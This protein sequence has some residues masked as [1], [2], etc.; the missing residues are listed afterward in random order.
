MKETLS[1][2]ISHGNPT[3]GKELQEQSQESETHTFLQSGVP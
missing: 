2:H 3:G 1:Y